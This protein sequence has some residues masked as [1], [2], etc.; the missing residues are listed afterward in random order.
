VTLV[1]GWGVRRWSGSSRESQGIWRTMR[2]TVWLGLIFLGLIG[3]QAINPSDRVVLENRLWRL[4]PLSPVAWAPKSLAAPF[5]AVPDDAL[6]Y[7]NAPRYLLVFGIAWTF[8]S[9]LALGLIRGSDARRFATLLGVNAG[10]LAVVCIVHVVTESQLTLWRFHGTFDFSH[11]PVFFYKNHNGAYLAASLALVLGLA[12]GAGAWWLR[13]A[14]EGVAFII[15]IATVMVDSRIATVCA[16]LLGLGYLVHSALRPSAASRRGRRW[17]AITAALIAA[18]GVLFAMRDTAALQRFSPLL[19]EPGDFIQGGEF[20]VL[21]RKVGVEMWKQRPI[22]GW[23]G[24]SF[25]Y[26]FNTYHTGVPELSETIYRQQPTLNRFYWPTANCDWVEFAVEYGGIGLLLLAGIAL[27]PLAAFFR[28]F[29]YHDRGGAFFAVGA[30]ALL[31][32]GFFDY[33]LRNPAI[34]ILFATLQILALISIWTTRETDPA[35][36]G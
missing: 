36:G 3:L 13:R 23:G 33:V 8:A 24:G 9:G 1:A 32:H 26:L 20:R 12:G 16:T 29:K 18:A 2:W 27:I 30:I 5:D 34:M 28:G 19:S 21:L 7:R 17:A 6:P 4:E 25:L 14:W 11:S 35:D 22:W 15:W 10:L 31:I